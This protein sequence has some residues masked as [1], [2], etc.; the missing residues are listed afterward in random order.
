MRVKMRNGLEGVTAMKEP[1]G[2]R[3]LRQEIMLQLNERLYIRELISKAV[4]E[5]A[6]LKIGQGGDI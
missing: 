1:Q 3:A 5:Q 4:Y 6:K 2:S